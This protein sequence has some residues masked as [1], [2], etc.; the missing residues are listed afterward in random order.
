MPTI[1]PQEPLCNFTGEMRE[2]ASLAGHLKG[3]LD[4]YRFIGMGSGEMPVEREEG[5]RVVTIPSQTTRDAVMDSAKLNDWMQVVGIFALVISL[6]FVGLQMRQ[7]RVL[8]AVE[9]TRSRSDLVSG[10]TEM[11]S[12][13]REL[14]VA[15]L[16]GEELSAADRATFEAMIESVESFFFALWIRASGNDEVLQGSPNAPI[17][18]YA[19]ALYVHKGLRHSWE[20]QIEYWR[21]RDAALN[22]D[23]PGAIF[24]TL[25]SAELEKL[26]ETAPTI[27]DEK[28]YVFW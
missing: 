26:D 5:S 13:N 18:S 15:A 24:R 27:P 14:W 16:D 9:S 12:D 8:A 3:R 20:R 25:V 21:V 4:S 28:R 23:D 7:D 19:F 2:G 22:T 11:I 6:I 1:W 10:L 17:G